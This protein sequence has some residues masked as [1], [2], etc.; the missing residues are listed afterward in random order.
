VVADWYISKPIQLTNDCNNWQVLTMFEQQ[1]Q[2]QQ[3][4]Q[5]HI[6]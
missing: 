3:Q 6:C 1:Q 2:Q 4:Q 5:Q